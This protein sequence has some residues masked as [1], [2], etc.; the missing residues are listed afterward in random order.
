MSVLFVPVTHGGKPCKLRRLSVVLGCMKVFWGLLTQNGFVF[1]LDK[2]ASWGV[3]LC[4]G[5]RYDCFRGLDTDGLQYLGLFRTKFE[6]FKGC[7]NCKRLALGFGGLGLQERYRY[8]SCRFGVWVLLH[9][10]EKVEAG[11]HP[12]SKRTP[13]MS[14]MSHQGTYLSICMYVYTDINTWNP[15]SVNKHETIYE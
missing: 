13:R 1:G 6:T 10:T 14:K 8:W 5:P 11:S 4:F 7:I 3:G 12:K 9:E 15:I 2:T